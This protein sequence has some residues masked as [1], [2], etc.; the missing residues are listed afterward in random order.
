M[1]DVNFTQE[2]AIRWI[3][4]WGNSRM[5][6]IAKE[7]LAQADAGQRFLNEFGNFRHFRE[8]WYLVLFKEGKERLN[9]AP[10]RRRPGWNGRIIW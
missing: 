5:A 7:I 6:V 10:R 1:K 4:T 9:Q 2:A 8:F 3:A